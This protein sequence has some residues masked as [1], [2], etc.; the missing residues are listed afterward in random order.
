MTSPPPLRARAHTC[1]HSQ[2]GVE[3]RLRHLAEDQSALTARAS[4]AE[5]M[6]RRVSGEGNGGTG[7]GEG[8]ERQR[9]R[10]LS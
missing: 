4:E 1:S 8:G 10:G 3:R 2:A 6:Q 5:L 7:D 9:E